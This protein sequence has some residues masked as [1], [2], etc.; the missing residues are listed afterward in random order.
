LKAGRLAPKNCRPKNPAAAGVSEL[1][2]QSRERNAQYTKTMH[3][4]AIQG[5]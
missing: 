3:A 4:K 5:G 1:N 2:S